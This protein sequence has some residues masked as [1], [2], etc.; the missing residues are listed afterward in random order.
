MNST[1]QPT[2]STGGFHFLRPAHL[3]NKFQALLVDDQLNRLP[4]VD[5]GIDA[6]SQDLRDQGVSVAS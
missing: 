4:V 2:A 6:G 5:S 1:W 3:V